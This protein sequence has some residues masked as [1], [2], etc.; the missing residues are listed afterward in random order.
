MS[1]Q[2]RSIL[3]L[4]MILF[5]ATTQS[6]PGSDGNEGVLRIPQSSR[7]TE[8]SPLDYLVSYLGH[9]LGE[10]YLTAETQLVY[11]A[12]PADRAN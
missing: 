10:F 2:F 4:D 11:S 5:G 7:I 8:A 6:R 12:A 9:L 1:T 3:P